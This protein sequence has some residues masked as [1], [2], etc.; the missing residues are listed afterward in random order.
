MLAAKPNSVVIFVSTAPHE[1]GILA[2]SVFCSPT[3]RETQELLFPAFISSTQAETGA[4]L[5][6]IWNVATNSSHFGNCNIVS[7]SKPALNRK[8]TFKKISPTASESREMF[9]AN[10]DLFSF[11]WLSSNDFLE[12]IDL[13]SVKSTPSSRGIKNTEVSLST[14]RTKISNKIQKL[15]KKEWSENT[16]KGAITRSFFPTQPMHIC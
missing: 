15:W 7:C 16:N 11:H 6:S 2:R 8:L 12:L 4:I 14:L 9:L 1:K 13:N 10:G 3:G 5:L